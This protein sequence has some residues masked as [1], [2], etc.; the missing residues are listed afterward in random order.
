LLT[1]NPRINGPCRTA[2]ENQYNTVNVSLIKKEEKPVV[3]YLLYRWVGTS[4]YIHYVI[5]SGRRRYRR[6]CIKYN[7]RRSY[8]H[9]S[10]WVCVGEWVC[11]SVCTW[12]NIPTNDCG[13]R[14]TRMISILRHARWT[15]YVIIGY[16]KLTDVN[17]DHC[18]PIIDDHNNKPLY[19]CHYVSIYF[20]RCVSLKK[21]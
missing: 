20:Y 21:R 12:Q 7:T 6:Y 9:V 14:I 16:E 4:L 10:V 13:R 1:F 3:I 17:L 11:V 2:Y 15:Y 8:I 18:R 19:L 5:T